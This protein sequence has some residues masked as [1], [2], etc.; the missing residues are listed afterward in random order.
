[1]SIIEISDFSQSFGDKII[2]DHANF[3]L[4]NNEK[5]GIVGLNGAGKGTLLKILEVDV[6]VDN[7][8]V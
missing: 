7:G 3:V 6:L 8:K 5:I 1:M 2:Y 4:N